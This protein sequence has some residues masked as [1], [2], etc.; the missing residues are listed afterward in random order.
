MALFRWFA[1]PY[2]QIAL[3]AF[4]VTAG[5]ISLKLGARET[6]ELTKSCP[7]AELRDPLGDALAGAIRLATGENVPH[8]AGVYFAR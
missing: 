4:I 3:N 1:N 6:A 8:L 2:L 5:E 7:Q